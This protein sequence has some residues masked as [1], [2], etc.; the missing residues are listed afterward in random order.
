MLTA[1]RGTGH[2]QLAVLLRDVDVAR[3]A[4]L[5][6]AARAAHAHDLGLDRDG[7]AARHRDGLF[8]DP[9]HGYQTYATTSPPTP[10]RRASWPVITPF[11]VETIVVPMP[12]WTFGMWPWSTYV[13]R[14]GLETR[15]IPEITGWRPSVYFRRTRSTWPTR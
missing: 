9:T 8:A 12:P 14:P 3:L 5:E 2:E 15:L 10:C 6:V 7:H 13:R 1:V 11:D 4:L